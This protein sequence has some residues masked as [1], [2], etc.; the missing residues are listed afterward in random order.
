LTTPTRRQQHS[1]SPTLTE[2][3][4][5]LHGIDREYNRLARLTLS[6][7]QHL[8]SEQADAVARRPSNG[9][10][11]G[12]V[13]VMLARMAA[14]APYGYRGRQITSAIGTVKR[15]L[16]DWQHAIDDA[17]SDRKPTD[18]DRPRCPGTTVDADDRLGG[19]GNLTER[20]NEGGQI[21]Y[22]PLCRTC[23]TP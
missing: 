11:S 20:Y 5:L 22:R 21:K 8:L 3:V 10:G 2:T 23:R 16:R 9:D 14:L 17:L 15:S 13:D 4:D 12:E 7:M 6:T 18:E 19:C 1:S